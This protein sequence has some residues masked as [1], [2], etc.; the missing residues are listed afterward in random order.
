MEAW[1]G[2]L[3]LTPAILTR[4]LVYQ[5]E[6]DGVRAGFV[7]LRVDEARWHL[8][9]LWV[10]PSCMGRGVGGQLFALAVRLATASGAENL[11]IKA[12]PH[13]ETFYL[14]QGAVRV[15]TEKY[16]LLGKHPRELPLL[17]FALRRTS[18]GT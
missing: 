6:L 8:E 4:E 11:H 14:K 7:G 13:A 16:L 3:T 12:D 1:R 18:S 5:A 10:E 17:S 2:E 9:H 15:G